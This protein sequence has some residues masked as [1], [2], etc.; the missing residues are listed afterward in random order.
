MNNKTNFPN[1]G[2]VVSVRGSVVDRH[3]QVNFSTR[4]KNI[5]HSLKLPLP[6]SKTQRPLASNPDNGKLKLN[7]GQD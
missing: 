5:I 4:Q 1:L 3:C 6:S 2:A 7:D